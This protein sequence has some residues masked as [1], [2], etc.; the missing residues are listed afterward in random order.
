MVEENMEPEINTHITIRLFDRLEEMFEHEPYLESMNAI[1]SHLTHEIYHAYS[2]KE[3]RR[4]AIN[5]VMEGLLNNLTYIEEKGCDTSSEDSED[6]DRIV[7]LVNEPG[8]E[9]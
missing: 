8:F 7:C 6:N 3:K 2:S 9:D 5:H 1:L 4:E